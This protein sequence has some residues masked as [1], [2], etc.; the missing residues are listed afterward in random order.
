MIS[1]KRDC[2]IEKWRS[3]AFE[4][5]SGEAVGEEEEDTG[6]GIGGGFLA[7]E[8]GGVGMES[9]AEVGANEVRLA[10]KRRASQRKRF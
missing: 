1:N 3:V 2:G 8:F 9:A 10:V 5:E 4:G 6:F 7:K